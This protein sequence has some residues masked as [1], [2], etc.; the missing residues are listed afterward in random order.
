MKRPGNGPATGSRALE[1]T[2]A[3]IAALLAAD[4]LRAAL[5]PLRLL[6]FLLFGT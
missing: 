5:E 3:A 1:F 2:L 4:S 6:R